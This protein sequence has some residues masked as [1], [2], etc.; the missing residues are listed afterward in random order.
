MQS[1]FTASPVTVIR[2]NGHLN[3]ANAP[4][5]GRE[6]AAAITNEPKATVLVDMEEVESLDSAGLMILVS[7][8]TLTQGRNQ[9]FSLCG[10]SPSIRII[11]ELTQLDRVFEIFENRVDF[12]NVLAKDSNNL[13]IA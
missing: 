1:R 4:E 10:I 5:F 6:L 2:P 12:E 8:L 3:A 7:A 13:A 9:R 11:F